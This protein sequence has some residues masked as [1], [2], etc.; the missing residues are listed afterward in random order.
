LG[1]GK[2]GVNPDGPFECIGPGFLTEA[3][4]DL[5]RRAAFEFL[6][7][8]APSGATQVS[9]PEFDLNRRLILMKRSCPF[10]ISTS[11]WVRE[12]NS[13]SSTRSF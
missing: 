2:Q 10:I 12:Q 4:A 6:D 11:I 1:A 9:A 7:P 3:E 13:D 8:T 5:Q